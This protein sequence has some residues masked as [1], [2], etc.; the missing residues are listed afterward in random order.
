MSACECLYVFLR[1]K[2]CTDMNTRVI[3]QVEDGMSCERQSAKTDKLTIMDTD[4]ILSYELSVYLHLSYNALSEYQYFL[5]FL[6]Y[7]T[8]MYMR[9]ISL[10]YK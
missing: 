10:W 1:S 5:T 4:N 2:V 3:F 9:R 7:V 8:F 6:E